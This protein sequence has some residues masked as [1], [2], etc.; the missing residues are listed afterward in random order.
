MNFK[1]LNEKLTAYYKLYII[2]LMKI[3]NE[4]ISGTTY[5]TNFICLWRLFSCGR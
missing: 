4:N 5:D 1:L 3:G 2:F